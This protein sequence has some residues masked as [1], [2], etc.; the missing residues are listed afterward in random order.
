MISKVYKVMQI[1]GDYA[2]LQDVKDVDAE[3]KL[4]ARALLPAD[5]YEGCTLKYEML[6]YEIVE[7]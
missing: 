5:I 4:V 3:W 1:D 6:E 2:R 7:A